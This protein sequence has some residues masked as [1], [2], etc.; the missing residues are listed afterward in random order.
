MENLDF[1][2]FSEEKLSSPSDL[3]KITE[4]QNI[5]EN[6]EIEDDALKQTE[7]IDQQAFKQK[8]E[9]PIARIASEKKIV[10]ELK[11]ETKNFNSLGGH[12]SSDEN[13][14]IGSFEDDDEVL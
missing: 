3:K 12:Y 1:K 6:E 14:K 8:E 4:T 13:N 5:N 9:K 2:Y 11:V 10:P 7:E